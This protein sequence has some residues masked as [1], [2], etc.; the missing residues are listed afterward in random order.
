MNQNSTPIALVI[1]AVLALLYFGRGSVSANSP[2]K[3]GGISSLPVHT[4]TDPTSHGYPAR[5]HIEYRVVEINGAT[6][7]A[8]KSHYWPGGGEKWDLVLVQK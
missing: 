6:Y 5:P 7:T 1:I 8:T 2:A 4:D 3:S